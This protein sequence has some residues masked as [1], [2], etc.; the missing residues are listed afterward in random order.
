MTIFALS[1][2]FFTRRSQTNKLN[3]SSFLPMVGVAL[4]TVTIILTFAIM[5]GLE[6]DIFETLKSFS[7]GTIINTNN[8]SSD[9]KNDIVNF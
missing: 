6:E 5:D 9:E 2:K 4:G 7:G 3:I 8:V 1:W